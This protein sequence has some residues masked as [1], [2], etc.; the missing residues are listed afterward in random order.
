M[1]RKKKEPIDYGQGEC[2]YRFCNLPEKKFK[3]KRDKQDFCCSRHRAAEWNL[4][5]PRSKAGMDAKNQVS[6]DLPPMVSLP[7]VSQTT[8][9]AVEVKGPKRKFHYTKIDGKGKRPAILRST[10]K[11][12]MECSPTTFEINLRTLSTRGSSDVS[13]LREQGFTS[14]CIPCKAADGSTVN[15]FQLTP[16]GREKAEKFFREFQSV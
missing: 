4:R 3:K 11:Y 1:S 15:R 16:E 6:L 5:N 12:L 14:E 13:E 7:P 8:L 2:Q 9:K 10:L